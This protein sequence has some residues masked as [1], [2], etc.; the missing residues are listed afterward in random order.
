M[1]E[2]K[3]ADFSYN[4][5]SINRLPE[6]AMCSRKGLGIYEGLQKMES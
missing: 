5:I 1:S 6:L 4:Y 2:F 3:L